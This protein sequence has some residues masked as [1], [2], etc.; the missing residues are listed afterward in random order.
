MRFI[1]DT[2]IIYVLNGGSADNNSVT[3]TPDDADI[4]LNNPTRE[5]YDFTG[6]E[7]ELGNFLGMT[8]VI[9]SGSIGDKT[10][11]AKWAEKQ[12]VVVS[13]SNPA[14]GDNIGLYLLISMI[15]VSGLIF[16]KKLLFN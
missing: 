2:N 14:T 3:Y 13:T 11:V 7:D 9:P 6:W 15:S 4:T 16:S 8:V 12:A 5:G 1:K 10:F